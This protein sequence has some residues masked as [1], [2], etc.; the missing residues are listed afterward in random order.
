MGNLVRTK[1]RSLIPALA[2][3]HGIESK[4]YDVISSDVYSDICDDQMVE[5]TTYW[6]AHNDPD[7]AEF[8]KYLRIVTEGG[9]PNYKTY[10]NK[11]CR[12]SLC[13]TNKTRK[14]NNNKWM[15]DESKNKKN[16]LHNIQ[17]Y[18][19]LPVISKRQ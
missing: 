19:G 12:K 8:I 11:E 14:L 2:G 18:I 4:H 5:L 3:V 9:K 13:W 15:V 7:F 16:V 10:D 1:S 6:R 17:V